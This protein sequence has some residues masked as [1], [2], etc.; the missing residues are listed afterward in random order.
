MQQRLHRASVLVGIPLLAA[1]LTLAHEPWQDGW[2]IVWLMAAGAMLEAFPVSLRPDV[3]TSL[4]N[5]AIFVALLLQGPGA[6]VAVA[7]ANG[8][9]VVALLPRERR[10]LKGPYN[11]GMFVLS[12]IAGNVAFLVVAGAPK[13]PETVEL[14]FWLL[15]VAAAQVAYY[16]VNI[17]LLSLAIHATGGPRPVES[18]PGLLLS[19]WWGQVLFPG[20][21]VLAF[22]V[23]VESGPVALALLLVPLVSARR[24]LAGVEAQRSSLDRAVRALVRLVEVKDAYTRGHAERVAD[25][26]D[27]VAARMGL[28]TTERFWIRIGAVLHDVGKICVPIEVLN[29]PGGFT[30]EE[31]WTMRRHP[32]LGA[33]LLER[34]DALAPAVP[35]VRQHHERIDGCGYP[36]GLAG[37][38]VPLATR[39][40]SAVDSW[41][42]MTTTRPYR[43]GLPIEVAVSELHRNS[44]TQFD[45]DVV[46]ALLLEVAPHMVM[47]SAAAERPAAAAAPREVAAPRTAVE[48]TS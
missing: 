10:L 20:L 7:V 37:D 35:L 39:I 2:I 34:V 27:R 32:D 18:L 16:L 45:A 1:G 28:S 25:L 8:L 40:V 11:V 36:R 44:G 19:A 38:E 6:A 33:D 4:S 15:G 23:Q 9:V 42:A 17:L 47:P 5:V 30:D 29:K 12:T 14:G 3:K 24:S 46:H 13:G 41:D 21:A 48:A 26:S 43:D 22:V 31:Y